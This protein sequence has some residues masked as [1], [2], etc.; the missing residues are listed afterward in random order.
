MYVKRIILFMMVLFAFACQ[1]DTLVDQTVSLSE[2]GWLQKNKIVIDF[3]VTDTSKA[4]DVRVA[5]RQSIEYPYYNLYF[6]PKVINPEGKVIKRAFAE[7]FLYDA[8]TGKPKGSGLGDMYSHQYT[9]FKGLHFTRLGKH[10]VSLEQYMR[11]DTLKG[12]I[13][14]GASIIE[15]TANDGQN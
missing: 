5:L 8:K 7:A 10:Q 6:V 9:I 1:N 13:S 2:H 14:A 4:Y 12:I 15:T 11:T 3:Q